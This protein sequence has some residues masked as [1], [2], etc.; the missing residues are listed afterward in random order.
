LFSEIHQR[1]ELKDK[2]IENK[3][4]EE[5]NLKELSRIPK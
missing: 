3:R 2:G 1:V 4:E 5:I